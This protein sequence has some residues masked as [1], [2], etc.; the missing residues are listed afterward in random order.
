MHFG[1]N[2]AKAMRQQGLNQAAL[3]VAAG[4]SQGAIS[5]YLNGKAS[6]KAQELNRI[7]KVLSV[8]MEALMG[9]DDRSL[10]AE[11][12][13]SIEE[14][15]AEK[16]SAS[17]RMERLRIAMQCTWA[18]VGEEIGLSE[19]MI[20]QVK[21]G[22][23]QLSPKAEYRLGVAERKAGL[24]PAIAHSLSSANSG[25]A[26]W[27][28]FA[29]AS[30]SEQIAM[31][32]KEPG[33]WSLWFEIQ[34]STIEEATRKE[35]KQATK[36]ANLAKAVA[37]NPEEKKLQ[38]EMLNIARAVIRDGKNLDLALAEMFESIREIAAKV[39]R[40]RFP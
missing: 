38:T 37:N 28:V 24:A 26:A 16:K 8:P 33:L 18:E 3:A 35:I 19:S 27:A 34:L 23:R 25:D 17:E 32:E 2:L 4:V 36:L 39:R 9:D 40:S 15:S 12:S 5:R 1:K 11:I 7:A 20:Y 6:P 21:S 10:L 13:A 31:L 29:K 14:F 30:A 22:T